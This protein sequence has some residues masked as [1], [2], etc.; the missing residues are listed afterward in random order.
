[1]P[2]IAL[3][4]LLILRESDADENIGN[5]EGDSNKAMLEYTVTNFITVTLHK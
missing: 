5:Y 4:G 2:S 3:Y 1:M